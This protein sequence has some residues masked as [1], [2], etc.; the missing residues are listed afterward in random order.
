[1]AT[2]QTDIAT[3]KHDIDLIR[4]DLIDLYAQLGTQVDESP[5]GFTDFKVCSKEF[6][7]LK[8][9]HAEI[10]SMESKIGY[11]AQMNESLS[12]KVNLSKLYEEQKRDALRRFS[13]SCAKLGALVLEL[14]DSGEQ[15]PIRVKDI[16]I[17][18]TGLNIDN[19]RINRLRALAENENSLFARVRSTFAHHQL[20]KLGQRREAALEILGKAIFEAQLHNN[21]GKDRGRDI[22]YE[23]DIINN[24]LSAIHEKATLNRNALTGTRKELAQEVGSKELVQKRDRLEAQLADCRSDLG[25]ALAEHASEWRSLSLSSDI[26]ATLAQIEERTSTI[27]NGERRIE[28]NQIKLKIQEYEALNEHDKNLIDQLNSQIAAYERQIADIR[29]TI[30]K[31]SAKIDDLKSKL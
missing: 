9:V 25:R 8:S 3:T 10:D 20:D 23:L 27:V 2:L 1:M 5:R 18:T 17:N 13:L 29:A 11:V 30:K 12:E 24:E 19:E 22:A 28:V 6:R 26:F 21:L 7:A 15:L 16:I 31:N 14:S 4:R